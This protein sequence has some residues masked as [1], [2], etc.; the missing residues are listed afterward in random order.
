MVEADLYNKWLNSKDARAVAV[1]QTIIKG[2]FRCDNHNYKSD[3]EYLTDKKIVLA[4]IK[5]RGFKL[6][7]AEEFTD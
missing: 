7:T 4:A 2:I 1:R 6:T 5:R 3:I